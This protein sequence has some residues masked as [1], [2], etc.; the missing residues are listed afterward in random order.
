MDTFSGYWPYK[1]ATFHIPS[2]YHFINRHDGMQGYTLYLYSKY[3][4]GVHYPVQVQPTRW[5]I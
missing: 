4:L 5:T 3:T 2:L 1:E